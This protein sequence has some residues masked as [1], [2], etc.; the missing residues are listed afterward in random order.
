M[1]QDVYGLPVRLH[2][3][4]DFSFLLRY[5]Q[6]FRVFDGQDS[7][8]VSFGVDSPRWGRLF[9]KFAGAPAENARCTPQQ[10]VQTLA[11][12]I[13]AYEALRHP[14]LVRLRGHGTVAGGYTA[15]FDW[16]DGE[17]L[18]PAPRFKG[19]ERYMHPDSPVFHLMHQPLLTRLRMIDSVFAFHLFAI[20]HGY[21]AVDFYDG[22]LLADFAT[23]QITVCDIDCYRPMPA[24]NDV[25]VLPGSARFR[26]PEEYTRGAPL[27][28]L[29]TQYNMGALAFAFFGERGLRERDA[30]TAGEALYQVAARGCAEER[31]ARY[32]TF[33]SFLSAWRQAAGDTAARA[34]A[35]G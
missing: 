24:F 34:G 31:S 33:N 29:S 9:I 5:G 1:I 4:W 7:G 22:S 2:A 25:G 23:G 12:A 16:T 27:D 18:Y 26:S 20:E 14:A 17:S 32:P 6:P 8:C 13:P 30:W 19:D 11:H 21:A 3:P 35:F 15:I 10:A 28:G